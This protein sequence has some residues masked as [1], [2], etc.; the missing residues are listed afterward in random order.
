MDFNKFNSIENTYQKEFIASLYERGFADN[1]YVVQEKAHGAN[2]SFITDGVNILCAKRNGLI[3][4]DENFY[5]FHT[6][7]SNYKSK[8]L[9]LFKQLATDYDLKKLTIF[10]ELIGGGYPHKEVAVNKNA[11]LVQR[12]IYYSPNNDFYAFDILINGNEYLD[13]ELAN[14]LFKKHGFLHAKTLFKGN[15]SECLKHSNKFK[16]I[17]P[18]QLGLP[19]LEENICEGIII[20]PTTPLFFNSG[21]RILIKNKNEAWS[22]NNN[23]IDKDLLKKLIPDEDD[24]SIEAEKLCQ[25]AYKYI[26]ENRLLNVISKIGEIDPKKHYG[27]VLGMFNKDILGDFFKEHKT[28]YEALEKHECKAINKFV[29]QNASL[30]VV[31]HFEKLKASNKN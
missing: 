16:S 13:V 17:I 26:T 30:L 23:H 12:G 18:K 14:T 21:S 22:E 7:L 4:K 19:E 29:N 24:L 20:R 28:A 15:L 25:E 8:C 3:E 5:N 11:K 2:L 31:D 9:E 1:D 6:V 27:K 10:G